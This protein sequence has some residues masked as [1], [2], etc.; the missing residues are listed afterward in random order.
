MMPLPDG[1]AE[2]VN[3]AVQR[4]RIAEVWAQFAAASMIGMS[5]FPMSAQ[6]ADAD[7][8]L[9][10]HLARFGTPEEQAAWE[11]SVKERGV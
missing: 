4:S 8:M 11:R 1:W 10:C 6:V 9:A 3:T 7:A 2:K 5:E